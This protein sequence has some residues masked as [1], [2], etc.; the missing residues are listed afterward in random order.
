MENLEERAEARSRNIG[1][2]ESDGAEV[3]LRDRAGVEETVSVRLSRSCNSKKNWTVVWSLF[4][5]L[6]LVG[7]ILGFIDAETLEGLKPVLIALAHRNG[8]EGV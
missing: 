5:L 6:L 4:C 2:D 1:V 8:T 3:V 7:T